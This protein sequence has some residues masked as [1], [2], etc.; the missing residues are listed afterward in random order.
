M[1]SEQR[2]QQRR[3]HATT[4]NTTSPSTNNRRGQGDG[5]G[6]GRTARH[7]D[8][9]KGRDQES[10]SA[11][12]ESEARTRN[13]ARPKPQ[14]EPDGDTGHEARHRRTN[15]RR[16]DE[17]THDRRQHEQRRDTTHLHGA[18]MNR[19]PP[20]APGTAPSPP[21]HSPRKLWG[22]CFFASK[23]VT[24]IR[25]AAVR[26]LSAGHTLQMQRNLIAAACAGEHGGIIGRPRQR[27]QGGPGGAGRGGMRPGGATRT[28]AQATTRPPPGGWGGQLLSLLMRRADGCSSHRKRPARRY[29]KGGRVGIITTTHRLPKATNAPRR[30][31]GGA[32]HHYYCAARIDVLLPP[33]TRA[34]PQRRLRLMPRRCFW[35][36]RLLRHRSWVAASQ[37]EAT[38]AASQAAGKARCLSRRGKGIPRAAEV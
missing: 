35:R 4:A 1:S 22:S 29:H 11:A 17:T 36:T 14:T 32:P 28:D 12:T 37:A 3:T 30:G 23:G 5:R 20:R 2:D 13:R 15:A 18:R 6:R 26:R 16:T 38:R 10:E 21:A 31:D 9:G 24:C 27:T 8:E 33:E 34:A 19:P 7:G 25:A